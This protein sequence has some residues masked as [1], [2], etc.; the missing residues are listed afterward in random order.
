MS[1]ELEVLWLSWASFRTLQWQQVLLGTM[2]DI[3]VGSLSRQLR[4]IKMINCHFSKLLGTKCFF[5][6]ID[7]WKAVRNKSFKFDET[8][9]LKF[10][11]TIW[12]NPLLHNVIQAESETLWVYEGKTNTTNHIL[13]LYTNH[14]CLYNFFFCIFPFNSR[15]KYPERNA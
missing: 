12:Y 15:C 4:R 6:Y 11:E 2:E 10:I 13:I 14:M 9:T 1:N 8:R 5:L 3:S 7:Q